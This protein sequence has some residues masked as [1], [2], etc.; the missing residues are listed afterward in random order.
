[1]NTNIFIPTKINVGFQNRKDTYTGK[2]AYV[3]YYDEKG[4]LRKE[5]SW[6]NWRDKEIPNEEFENEPI[7]G[8]VLNRRAG[9]VEE[10]W[11]WNPRKTYCRVYDPRGFEFEITIANLLWILENCNSIKGKGLEGEFVYGWDGKELV[12]VPIESPDYKEIQ[13]KNKIV[14]NNEFIKAKDL[15]IGATYETLKGDR[16]V[17]MGRFDRFEKKYNQYYEDPYSWNKCKVG[18]TY[19]LDETWVKDRLYPMDDYRYRFDN[20][21]KHFFFI[22][23]CNN[24]D[25]RK[26][27]VETFKS[28]T[29]KFSKVVNEQYHEKYI[30]FVDMLNRC[31]DYSPIDYNKSKIIDLPFE[32]F[33][34]ALNKK[35]MKMLERQYIY[36][37]YVYF[38]IN[39]NDELKQIRVFCNTKE[40]KFYYKHLI[41]DESYN[42]TRCKYKEVNKYFDS[43]EE[44]YNVLNPVYGE[45]YLANGNLY[46]RK[47]YHE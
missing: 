7:E 28:V 2:L 41:P 20:K 17:Y 36:D 9:G 23:L 39:E 37:D 4:K 22:D 11:G 32:N 43:I 44:L 15:I 12:L 10:S 13:E 42:W 38:G 19:P 31:S 35:I 14:H 16:Y 40:N 27:C 24:S 34:N 30:D 25:W 5:A 47:Y 45:Y 6:Q 46:E 3:V 29:R 8:F 1:M 21:G 18:W 33:A 26:E